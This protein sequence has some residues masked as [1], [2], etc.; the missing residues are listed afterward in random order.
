M[1]KKYH[2]GNLKN[3]LISLSLSFIQREGAEKLTLK[4]LADT[5]NTSSSAIYKH[6]KSKDDLI[7]TLIRIGLKKF[8]DRITAVFQAE[9]KSLLDRFFLSGKH[10]IRFARDNAKMYELLFGSSHA[11]LKHDIVSIT[12]E[13]WNGFE[14]L[15]SAVEEGQKAGFF[16]LG[17]SYIKA[18][19][20][21]SSL[22]GLSLLIINKFIDIETVDS[23]Y[24]EMYKNL[25]VG[26]MNDNGKALYKKNL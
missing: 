8:D 26:I 12:N 1:G 17:D 6:F 19:I 3:E 4:M 15:K 25:L 22:H 14:L 10:Y 9:D 11:H 7:Q 5:T 2:H 16:Q 13:E 20:I 18:I 24:E 21:W 23:L